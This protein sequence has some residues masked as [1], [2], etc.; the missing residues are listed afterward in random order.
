M[1]DL[2]H[3]LVVAKGGKCLD[4]GGIFPDCCMDF[5]HRDPNEKSFGIG[6]GVA[7][8][9]SLEKLMIE[10]DKCDLVC[11]NCHRIRTAGNPVI[12][13]KISAATKGLKR[14]PEHRAKM[15]AALM[16]NKRNPY[17]KGYKQSPETRAK[18]TA[19]RKT[20]K[21]IAETPTDLLN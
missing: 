18:I 1:S 14:T 19:T 3:Q 13:Q 21:P 5:D 7:Q 6:E 10:A 16:G 15:S 9:K 20:H 4:C 12:S 2:K 11:S 8:H 17:K